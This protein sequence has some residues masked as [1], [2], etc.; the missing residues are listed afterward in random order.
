MLCVVMLTTNAATR[1]INKGEEL[2]LNYGE[3]Y[4]ENME[5]EEVNAE[6]SK[7]PTDC[8]ATAVI[9][10]TKLAVPPAKKPSNAGSASNNAARAE[11]SASV[12]A[13]SAFERS[14]LVPEN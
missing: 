12:A 6:G 10:S 13:A 5:P 3:S 2:L 11:A 9:P 7:V 1:Q 8:D 4:W 14:L